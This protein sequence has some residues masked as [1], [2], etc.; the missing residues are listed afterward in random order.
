MCVMRS[1]GGIFLFLFL[2]FPLRWYC[3]AD[4]DVE[5]AFALFSYTD[6]FP[7]AILYDGA[8]YEHEDFFGGA[9]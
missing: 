7:P 2:L 8:R 3:S 5:S 6:A 9:V 4:A 1:H